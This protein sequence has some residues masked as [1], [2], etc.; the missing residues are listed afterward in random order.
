M[1]IEA[2][3]LP[4]GREERK[5]DIAENSTGLDLLKTL[6]LSPDVHILVRNKIPIPLD[7]E[8]VDGEKIRIINVVSGG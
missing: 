8:L 1:M 2:V 6:D 4:R 3:F 7:E 5:I